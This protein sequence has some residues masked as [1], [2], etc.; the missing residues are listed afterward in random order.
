MIGG[1][2]ETAGAFEGREGAMTDGEIRDKLQEAIG[3]AGIDRDSLEGSARDWADNP[4]ILSIV[5]QWATGSGFSS[6]Q[7]ASG[8]KEISDVRISQ[9]DDGSIWIEIDVDV[10]IDG[11]SG[12]V[13]GRTMTA[14]F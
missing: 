2:G 13:G 7:W 1:K 4:D 5:D 8:V 9:S 10:D 11:D 12:D 3:N 6:E 14:V